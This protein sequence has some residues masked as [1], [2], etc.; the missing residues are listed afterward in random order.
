MTVQDSAA[1]SWIARA[2]RPITDLA[3]DLVASELLTAMG[4]TPTGRRVT[5]S[6]WDKRSAVLHRNLEFARV[7]G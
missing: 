2:S 5:S 1:A 4:K 7:S 3:D 6:T